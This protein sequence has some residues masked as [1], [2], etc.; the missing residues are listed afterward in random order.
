VVFGRTYYSSLAKN[1]EFSPGLSPGWVHNY[2][3]IATVDGGAKVGGG[4]F[5]TIFLR[6]PKGAIELL[7]AVDPVYDE[8]PCDF[9]VPPGANYL[10]TGVT[11]TTTGRFT[12][13]TLAWRDGTVWEFTPLATVPTE[14]VLTRITNNMGKYL[15]LEY[16]TS[17]KLTA[18]SNEA[19]TELLTCGYDGNGK[20]ASVTDAYDREVSYTF[21]TPQGLAMSCLTT[22]SQIVEAE[23]QGPP[24]RYTYGYTAYSNQPMLHTI[25]VPSATGAGNATATINYDGNGNVSSRVDALGN[26]RIYTYGDPQTG[27]STVEVKKPNDD[28][29]QSWTQNYNAL[30]NSGVTD[31]DDNSTVREYGDGD[32]PYRPTLIAEKDG[33]ET[34]YTYDDQGNMLTSTTGELTTTLTYDYAEFDFGRLESARVGEHTAT[35]YTYY[36]P[37]GLVETV[38]S[39]KPG[40]TTGAMV[41]ASYTYDALG[42]M[43][44]ET[45]PGNNAAASVTTTYNY[46][47]DG[48]Y[49][50]AAAVGQPLTVT[51]AL[52]QAVHYRYDDR[53]NIAQAV[54]PLGMKTEWSYN[55]ADQVTEVRQYEA[56]S[57]TLY[58]R[59]LTTYLYPGGPALGVEIY[60]ETDT[61][62]RRG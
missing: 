19:E 45:N 21:T 59:T 25:T 51:D 56:N 60:D 55:L 49:Q 14:M 62:A 17:R 15:T 41:T 39:P 38:T 5:A 58:R 50:Q 32:Q 18:V 24:A 3:V 34:T 8:S 2:D 46:T 4:G 16:D 30:R 31:A 47:G 13:L 33:R 28:P 12:E 54:D 9:T 57:V 1:N 6:Y 35:T 11:S 10:A 52:G 7:E 29:V 61:L 37:S 20:L 44:T 36:E 22:V 43:L 40:S 23:T 26:Q 53:G 42:N 27:S 48:E